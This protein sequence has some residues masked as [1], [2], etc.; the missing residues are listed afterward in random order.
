MPRPESLTDFYQHYFPELPAVPPPAVGAVGQV[1][2]FRLEAV[3]LP[4]DKPIHYGR[5]DFYKIA[6]NRGPYVYHYADKSVEMP[7]P[8]LVFFNPRVLYGCQ[9]L[10]AQPTGFYCLFSEVFFRGQ[11][12]TG[13]LE[14]PLFQPGGH[15]AYALTPDQE[16]AVSALFETMLAEIESD[17]ALKYDLL[18]HYTAELIHYALKLRP[19][20]TLYQQPDAKLRLT[21]AFLDLL[22]RQFPVES[23]THRF[24]L[25][26]AGDF[27]G[28][29]NVHVNYLNRCVR[30]VTG[31]TTT[32]HIA[33]RVVGEARALLRH[34]DWNVAEIGY[35]LGFDEPTRFNHFFKKQT[36][37]A[38]LAVRRV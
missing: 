30:E 19:T 11:P 12:G 25:R 17:Y 20:D 6:L 26:S 32:T 35:S 18:R 8:T 4:A 16:T 9:A 21:G 23:P 7:G 28:Q 1:N 24:A 29:L 3:R 38:P 15:P 37:Q 31:K 2:V 22:E 34:T 5:R 10:A 36:G 33:E 27:A 14:Q 13:L